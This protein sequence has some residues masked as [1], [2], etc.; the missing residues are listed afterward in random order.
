VLVADRLPVGFG[1]V[2]AWVAGDGRGSHAHTRRARETRTLLASEDLLALDWVVGEKMSLDPNQSFVMQE[3]LLR[4][5]RVHVV[6]RGN[7]TAWAPWDNVW[8][9]KV[10]GAYLLEPA[11]RR[12]AARALYGA[13]GSRG[14]RL[15]AW[16][17]Q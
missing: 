3:A 4:W 14:R 13:L 16:T 10:A 1:I 5:G 17:V 2:D 15:A 7:T 12:P 8:P 9:A 6:R 11:L